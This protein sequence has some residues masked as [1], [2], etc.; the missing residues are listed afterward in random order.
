M[1]WDHTTCST[2]NNFGILYTMF[3]FFLGLLKNKFLKKPHF[4]EEK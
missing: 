3:G 4:I 2:H 1:V